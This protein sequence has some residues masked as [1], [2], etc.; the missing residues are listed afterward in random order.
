MIT[1]PPGAGKSTVA[2]R[3]AARR[4][5]SVLIEGDAFFAFL[6]QGAIPPWLPEADAQ[7]HVVIDAAAA[8]AGRYA[9]TYTTVYDG[10]V[11]PWFL[12][13]FARSTGLAEL[14]Y[15]ILLPDVEQCLHRVATRRGHR[16]DDEAATRSMHQQFEDSAMAAEYVLRSSSDDPQ[17]VATEVLT[18]FESGRIAYQPP[19]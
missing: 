10:I 8:A 3:V 14:H 18:R 4:N 12:P 15:V 6:D 13:T 5:P 19:R 9:T 16:F 7:N 11:G 2:G 1:G 17:E